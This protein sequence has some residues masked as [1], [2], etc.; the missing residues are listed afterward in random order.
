MFEALSADF[1]L[2]AAV[3][4]SGIYHGMNPGMGWPLAVSAALM[5]KRSR[6][7]LPALGLLALG[8]FLAMLAMLL[9]FS[10]M[11]TLV[12]WEFQ[13][14][15]G[16][17]LILIA[18]GLFLFIYNKH[19]RFLSRVRP[20]RLMFWSFLIAIAHGAGLML[21]PIYLGICST[22][23][24]DAG[25]QAAGALMTSN[26][27]SAFTVSAVHTLAMMISGGFIAA[28]IY[29]WLGLKFLSSAWFNLDRVW[30]AS[31]VLVGLIS[32]WMAIAAPHM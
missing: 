18:L 32:A 16:A 23:Q 1:G 13:I 17:S 6:A 27:L 2:W 4:L 30:A 11:M 26:I 28:I 8:H 14:R 22:D 31:L 7:L 21:V 24:L 12:L 3:I 19:P 5:K 9:P 10:L 25:H 29:F 15:M 20:S